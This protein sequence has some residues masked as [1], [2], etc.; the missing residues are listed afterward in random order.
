ME[1]FCGRPLTC[2][3]MTKY[4][5]SLLPLQQ[6]A[7]RSTSIHQPAWTS[8]GTTKAATQLPD[9][10]DLAHQSDSAEAARIRSRS[11][12]HHECQIPLP[13]KENYYCS[14]KIHRSP[15]RRCECFRSTGSSWRCR[16]GH[17]WRTDGFL[18]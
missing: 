6:K 7:T 2:C 13:T 12:L 3:S 16:D 15:E 5:G 18:H 10:P 14:W 11:D 4:P 9:E 8:L 1:S 17:A